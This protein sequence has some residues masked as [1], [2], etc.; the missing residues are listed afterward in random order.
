M[1][2][3][4]FS[5][6]PNTARFRSASGFTLIELMIVVAIIGIL[7]AIAYP[8]YSQYKIRT[9]RVDAQAEMQNIA[10]QLQRFKIANFSFKPNGTAVTLADAGSNGRIPSSGAALY[11]LILS[12]VNGGTWTL[13]A[14][15]AGAQTGDGH[16]VLN[17][18]GQRCWTKG[19]DKKSGTACEPSATSNWDGR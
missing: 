16:L 13:T 3:K 15:P 5:M 7:A 6:W 17:H 1:V 12:N 9:Q 2:T 19:S 4:Y 11:N 8:S 10:N 18:R 14:T